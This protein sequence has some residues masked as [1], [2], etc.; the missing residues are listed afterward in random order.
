MQ[1]IQ[2]VENSSEVAGL[3]FK[4]LNIQEQKS[5]QLTFNETKF[6]INLQFIEKKFD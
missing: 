2:I 4:A 6:Q 1:A 5:A 3:M